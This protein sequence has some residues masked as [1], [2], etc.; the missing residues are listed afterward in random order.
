MSISF[1]SFAGRLAGGWGCFLLWGLCSG[2]AMAQEKADLVVAPGPDAPVGKVLEW[3]SAPDKPYWYRLPDLSTETS[4][5]ADG[6]ASTSTSVK[7]KPA[8]ILMLHG[9]GLKWGWAF[10]NYSIAAGKFRPNDIV[11]APEGMT[12]GHNGTFNF[13][14][15]KKDGEHLAGLIAEFREAYE[16]DRVY[17]YGHSQG[18]F[19][20]YWF[21]G[22]YPELVDG[23]VA[24][25]G[26]V[27]SVRHSKRSKENVAI[28]I[29]HGI[30]DAVVTVDCAYRTQQIYRDQEYRKVRLHAVEG[31]T[32]KSGHW[33]LPVQVQQML[34]WLDAVT[35]TDLKMAMQELHKELESADP[36]L[37]QIKSV[38]ELSAPLLKKYKGD[39]AEDLQR[40]WDAGQNRFELLGM[41]HGQDLESICARVSGKTE[42]ASWVS[43]F[44]QCDQLY[45]NVPDWMRYSKKARGMVGRHNKMVDKALAGLGV[46]NPKAFAAGFKALE[47]GF[48]AHRYRELEVRMLNLAKREPKGVSADDIAAMNMLIQSRQQDWA[49]GLKHSQKLT[50]DFIVRSNSL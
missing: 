6:E 41:I 21:A 4:K 46:A 37:Q 3:N 39:D 43:H 8:L 36:D 18:A 9:T 16:I 2:A 10:W 13:V 19:F 17:L 49:D 48:L 1:P 15:G 45:Q 11:V 44:N 47:N 40:L 29:L 25:A 35:I 14:Q 33:P 5:T 50:V 30:A 31:L 12:P 22:E 27:L 28:G 24:H 26:N 23:I 20:C 38:L 7:R 34:D 32:E 42:F